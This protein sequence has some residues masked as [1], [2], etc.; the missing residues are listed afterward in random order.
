MKRIEHKILK[1]N[2]YTGS[3]Q[4]PVFLD[5]SVDEMGVMVS[6]DGDMEQIEQLCNFTYK[7][8]GSTI[9]IYNSVNPDKL[10]KITEQ[11]FTINWGDG[12]TSGLTVNSGLVGS[13]LPSVSKTY[14]GSTQYTITISSST[15]WSTDVLKKTITVPQNITVTNPLGTLTGI[16][17][18]YT[19]LT[20]RTIN[21]LNDLEYTNTTGHTTFTY[22]AIGGSRIGELRQYGSTV[23]SGVTTG[24]TDNVTWSGYTIDG[25]YYR[26]RSDGFTMITGN[27]L[28]LIHI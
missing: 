18:P 12:T 14:T 20:G 7:Q 1:S 16:T 10:R 6:F 23:F 28:S 2:D 15:P 3:Y 9:T 19:T 22:L 8:S 21:Y 13:N 26:D 4:I 11:T 25:L 5:S 17:I 24:T 27:T